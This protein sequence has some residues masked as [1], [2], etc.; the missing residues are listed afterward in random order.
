MSALKPSLRAEISV[1]N[2]QERASMRK[3]TVIVATGFVLRVAFILIAHTYRF[4][5]QGD[6]FS[7]GYEM[8]RIAASLAQGHGFSSPFYVPTGPTAWQPPLYPLLIAAVFK[9][10]G[11]YSAASAIILLISNSLFSALTAAP[12]FFLAWRSFGAKIATW[13]AWVWTL[14]PWAAY[15][16]VKWVWETSIAAFLL[17]V[18]LLLAWRIADQGRARD[19]AVFG[20]LWGVAALLNTSLLS[21][22]PI[23][24]LWLFEH[25]RDRQRS[26]VAGLLVAALCFVIVAAPWVV[27]NQRT[28]H[29]FV[30]MR[31]NFGVELRIGNGPGANGL[32]MDYLHP[33]HNNLEFAKY[34]E[35]GEIAY[36]RQRKH[37][38]LAWIAQNPAS[39]A[40]VT[41]ARLVYYWSDLPWGGR[42]MPPKNALFLASS[43][44]A[45]WGLWLMRKQRR[46]GW[47]L[48]ALSLV[49]FPLVYYFVFPHPRYRGPIEPE[50][51]ILIVYLIS[52]TS[53]VSKR[54]M[55]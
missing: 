26:K 48:Y 21:V 27:R 43:M 7:F 5:T 53:T 30:L 19:W 36:T 44:C 35:M 46:P 33:T 47:G 18:L 17:C 6:N 13:S 2:H 14:S 9:V 45:F 29:Q 34:R 42:F 28:F 15:W 23:L 38:A 31:S 12:I 49:I 4:S 3:L 54:V 24:V 39:F 10:A 8:G 11:I 32:A 52:Q 40:R 22:L 37:E 55:S 50:I 25:H 1:S 16:A 41:L 51:T 20:V